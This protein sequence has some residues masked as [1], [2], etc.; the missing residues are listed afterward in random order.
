MR[1]TPDAVKARLAA[2]LEGFPDI[3]ASLSL[4]PACLNGPATRPVGVAV[5]GGGDSVALLLLLWL[6]GQRPLEVFSVDHGINPLSAGWTRDVE[7]LGAALGVRVHVL[8]WAGEKPKTGLQAAARR[9]RHHLILEAARAKGIR[10]ICLG[11]NA[12][13]AAEAA[14]M[15]AEGSNVS[16]PRRWSPA[17]LWPQGEGIFYFRPLMAIGRRR[18]RDWL[19]ANQIPYVDDP[20]NANPAYLRARVRQKGVSLVA[21]PD[22]AGDA[23]AGP[24]TSVCLPCPRSEAGDTA[25]FFRLPDLPETE[26]LSALI[27]CAGGGEKLPRRAEV[28]RILS[29]A[30]SGRTRFT[31]CGAR[32]EACDGGWLICR[33]PGDMARNGTVPDRNAGIWGDIWGD[34]WDG[35][36]RLPPYARGAQIV[37]A[38]GWLKRLPPEDR[39]RLAALPAPVRAGWPLLK[40]GET[41]R[42]FPAGD[43]QDLTCERLR[44][45]L[46]HIACEASLKSPP[47]L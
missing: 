43:L 21:G 28:R 42:L 9:A 47:D 37:M 40:A 17:P 46:G 39:A 19:K 2:S 3:A 35:R 27:V 26:V 23:N 16:A 7:A 11:H 6:W 15:R 44:A 20:A 18:L 41:V 32:I 29:G 38:R 30:Q 5:S 24:D 14:A 10:V 8:R 31:L 33:E 22:E 45:A 34:I 1:V 25:G 4:F 12:D 36:W 13:D